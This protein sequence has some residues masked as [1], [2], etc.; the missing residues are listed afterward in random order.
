MDKELKRTYMARIAQ[1]NRSELVV[2][3]FE[4][5]AFAMDTAETAF[6]EEDI[7]QGVFYLKKAQECLCELRGSLDFQYPV[8]ARLAQLYQ[9]VNTRLAQGI[10]RQQPVDFPAV[11]NVME[12]LQDSFE[13]VASEDT[14]G[15]VMENTQQIYAGLTYGKGSLNEV[16]T[17]GNESGRGFRA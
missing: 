5:F 4:M 13:K 17:S 14:T 12:G 15:P 16:V 6:Q 11:R 3:L 1:A 7:Q 8:S 10:A 9:F 2:I